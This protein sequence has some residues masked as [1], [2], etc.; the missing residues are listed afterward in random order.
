MASYGGLLGILIGLTK[1]TDHPNRAHI[2]TKTVICSRPP[3]TPVIFR[4]RFMFMLSNI[5]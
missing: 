3:P 2:I 1:S 5:L 4:K